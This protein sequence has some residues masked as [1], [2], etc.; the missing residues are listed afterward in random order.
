[1]ITV[2]LLGGASL[3][4]GNAP[5]AGPPA[6]RHR[7]ALLA[8]VVAAWPQPL[9]RDRAMALLWPER[10]QANAR[11]L[12]NLA[13]HV[14]RSTLGESAIA[15][16][17]DALLLNPSRLSCDLHELRAAIAADD[18]ERV[19]RLYTGPLL[20]GFHLDDSTEFGYWLDERRGE[21]AHA[22]VGA[23]LAL[24]ERQERS[25]DV[26]GRVGTCRRLVAADPYSGAYAQA[27]LRALDASGDR[28]GVIQHASEYA[29]RLRV[30]LDL[31][32]DPE[33]AAL[34]ERLRDGAA[35]RRPTPAGAG[36]TRCA[37][38]AVLPFLSLSADPANEYFAD[39]ITEDVIAHLSKIR[40]LTVIARGSV[41]PFKQRERSLKEIGATLGATK[42]LDGSV[43]HAGDRVRIVATLLDVETDRQLWA[44]TYDRRLTDIFSIQTDVALCIAAALETELSPAERT[45]V[46]REPTN[47]IQA[48]QLFLQGRQLYI[49]YTPDTSDR[50]IACFERAVARDPTFALAYAHLAML[51]TESAENGVRAPDVAYRRAAEA[52]ARALTLDPE[53]GAA[54][55]T[56]GY[57]KGVREF[58]WAGAEQDFKRALELSPSSADTLDLYGRLCAALGR[59]DEA[60]ALQHRAHEL[61][62]LAHRI[63]GVTTLLR[64]GRYHEAVVAAE[65]AVELDPGYDRARATL[66]WAYFLTGRQ[67]DGLAELE[68]AVS[69]SRA[70][71]LWL[72]QLGEAHAMAGNAA[73]AR[74]LLRELEERAQRAYVSPYHFAYVYTGLGD[75]DRAL[76][77]LE[78]AVADRTGPAYGIKGSFLFTPLHAHPRFRALLRQM[79]LA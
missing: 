63:D 67:D 30:D 12:L 72:G 77:W 22:Y 51:Y 78:R 49:R 66:G 8:L 26:H 15:S 47:D 4:S 79:N 28:A 46:R 38:V 21:I 24:A 65:E 6:Q 53:L 2:Q 33:V 25:G 13:V 57:L 27:L 43:R 48:Y 7:I 44:E 29:S 9:S 35:R 17:G 64:A 23:L 61:D 68:R 16:A 3:R 45:R 31:E 75:A 40:A 1:M 36:P 20:D 34:A 73:K 52:A 14:L 10:D 58:D 69:I 56:M 76:D 55:C 39:G 74:E 54:H 18:Y 70:N 50:A 60:L 59:Y 11:R 19:V 32:P 62:P 71:T 42:L 41:M 37:S 5:V